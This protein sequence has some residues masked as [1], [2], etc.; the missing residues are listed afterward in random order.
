MEYLS[1][2]QDVPVNKA[3]AATISSAV[4]RLLQHVPLFVVAQ[5]HT[6]IAHTPILQ[7]I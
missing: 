7:I 4:V 6:V 5:T 2:L 1:T 3:A